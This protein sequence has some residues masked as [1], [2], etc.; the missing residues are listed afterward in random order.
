MDVFRS[1]PSTLVRL[2]V[3][4]H[5]ITRGLYTSLDEGTLGAALDIAAM[6]A[7][8]RA[9]RELHAIDP[10][11]TARVLDRVSLQKLANR[12]Q[13]VSLL[14]ISHT[15]AELNQADP[16]RAHALYYKIPSELL[17]KKLA[18]EQLDFQQLGSETRWTKTLAQAKCR[19]GKK[20]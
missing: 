5:Q 20:R 19:A 13:S 3:S 15:L 12:L 7:F 8:G 2:Q 1:D 18:S 4:D 16:D 17:T 14:Q 9:V 6:E 11:K 10:K